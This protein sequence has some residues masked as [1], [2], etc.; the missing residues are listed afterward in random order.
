MQ[1]FLR[2]VQRHY[3]IYNTELEPPEHDADVYCACKSCEYKRR[4]MARYPTQDMWSKAVL[5]P[6][7]KA[8][9]D[10]TAV[11][12]GGRNPYRLGVDSPY[13]PYGNLGNG[14]P[15]TGRGV[16]AQF[17]IGM[18]PGMKPIPRYHTQAIQQ[19]IRLNASLNHKAQSNIDAREPK[20][21]I[22]GDEGAST[23]EKC[24][25]EKQPNGTEPGP[26]RISKLSRVKEIFH[27]KSAAHEAKVLRDSILAEELG[28]WPDEQC[29]FIVRVYQDKM[30]MTGKIAQLRAYCP[31]QYLHLLRAGYFEPIPVAW[32]DSTS[33]PLK[34][35]VDAAAGQSFVLFPRGFNQA[36]IF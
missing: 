7:E 13:S 4:K 17:N 14:V 12:L 26:S 35:T 29:R 34:F 19:T 25:N 1:K 28:R 10:N 33:N 20:E 6:G 9:N 22:W 27:L 2:A 16:L 36:C 15:F 18:G 11:L 24:A 31:I 5:Y 3:Q 32:A 23:N 30:G 21:I 8:Y